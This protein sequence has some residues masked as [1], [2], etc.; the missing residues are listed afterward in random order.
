MTTEREDKRQQIEAGIAAQESLRG[1]VDDA[2]IEATIAALR[3]QL[4]ELDQAAARMA[5][6]TDEAAAR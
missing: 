6:P 5:E 4:A 3:Q 1:S 2:I